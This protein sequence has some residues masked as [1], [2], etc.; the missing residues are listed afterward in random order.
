MSDF[1]GETPLSQ[2]ASLAGSADAGEGEIKA[3]SPGRK[4]KQS[5]KNKWRIR[6]EIALLSGPAILVF[7]AFVIFPVVMAAYYGFFKWKGFGIPTD[8]VGLQ[9]FTVILQDASFFDV[10]LYY[11]YIIYTL[12]LVSDDADD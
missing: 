4:P 10:L 9:N 8:F 5:K 7:L 6:L 12:L 1:V 11:Y 2:A 3:P